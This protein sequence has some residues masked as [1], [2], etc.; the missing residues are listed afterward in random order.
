V[1]L[2][3]QGENKIPGQ[4]IPLS[5]NFRSHESVLDFVNS[6]FS[7][8]MH[9]QTGGV[10]YDDDA[11]LIF[12][13]PEQRVRFSRKTTPA[14]QVELHIRTKTKDDGIVES[15]GN[16]EPEASAA[17][18]VDLDAT[19]KEA[20]LVAL[21]LKKLREEKLQIW[22]DDEKIS[23][24]VEW[25]DMVVLLR[26]PRNKAEI[27][28]REFN[29]VGVPLHV[30]RESFYNATEIS[31]LISLLQ[32]LD[33]PMQDLPLLAVLRSPLVGLS[34]D[35]LAM[36]RAGQHE[37]RFWAALF[38]FGTTPPEFSGIPGEIAAVARPKLK[39]FLTSFDLWRRHA[40]QGALSNC[41]RAILDET[42][43]ES[44][45]L[46]QERG[47]SRL[48]NVNRL[49]R[50]MRQFDPYQR[51]GLLRFL[52]FVEA[53]RD[54]EAE[55]EPAS[56]A[57]TD[58]VRLL[59]IHQSKGLEFPLVAVADL[60]KSF[61]LADLRADILL[62]A[63]FGLCPRIAPPNINAR[64]PSLP[65][66]LARQRQKR[67]L[68]G[69]ELRLLYVAMT[70]ARD[71]LLLVGS[72]TAKQFETRW[73][74]RAEIKATL[75]LQARSYADWLALWFSENCAAAEGDSGETRDCR[76]T[77]HDDASLVDSATI[78]AGAKP[79]TVIRLSKTETERLRKKLS[80]EYS[81]A[82]ATHEPAKTSVSALRRRAMETLEQ[83]ET[84]ELFR[85]RAREPKA[86]EKAPRKSS[87]DVG[88]VY[89]RFL[90][91]VSFEKLGGVG[92][93][94][95]EA[96]RMMGEG[97]LVREE[98]DYLN[99]N[100]VL[101]FWRSPVGNR[102]LANQQNVRRELAFTARFSPAELPAAL[103][104]AVPKA[105]ENEFVVVQGVADVAVMLPNEIWLLDFKTDRVTANDLAAKTAIYQPQLNLYAQA[106][107]RIYGKPV[108]ERWLHFLACDETVSVR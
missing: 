10:A 13:A 98:I 17:D 33:N 58:A 56:S 7:A 36:I 52:R 25:R 87:A 49:L 15:N 40:R 90:E 14:P 96:E 80:A 81:F 12:G 64:Y 35:E 93:L 29:R 61:N 78:S 6:F 2:R 22:D 60:A 66:W 67:E 73:R 24:A 70:R 85:P 102:I 77:L 54:A 47:D 39:A 108:T 9:E 72:V 65:Y 18:F 74:A 100:S 38:K 4:T 45:I 42:H 30:K 92:D 68:L 88:T 86:T 59:S 106:F 103:T 97:V 71:R 43:Y 55:E 83:E 69:E 101:Q 107:E 57:T 94:R 34:V 105:M 16:G 27:F 51:Q 31:D 23:R 63:E 46:A 8:F 21:Q 62:D 28:A 26:S 75:P 32:L 20:R 3:V 41:M 48:A 89:H 5:H 79:N 99:F 91:R 37:D 84:V 82:A 104:P 1:V 95:A 53:Q 50:L 11:R 19:E 44:L 76:W